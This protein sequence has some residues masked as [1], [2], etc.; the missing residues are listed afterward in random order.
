MVAQ[1]FYGNP[2]LN[3]DILVTIQSLLVRPNVSSFMQTSRAFYES[4]I[5]H[6]MDSPSGPVVIRRLPVT[7]SFCDFMLAK[8]SICVRFDSLR[9]SEI[10]H[11]FSR[12]RPCCR[13][14]SPSSST[15]FLLGETLLHACRVLLPPIRD[16]ETVP[17][18][19]SAI[20][21]VEPTR[22]RL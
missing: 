22:R 9:A 12:T 18:L 6:I 16:H 5:P 10:P 1:I 21:I 11:D 19:P 15:S 4:G 2:R 17:Q 8:S 20:D 13:E 7:E 3:F 14:V